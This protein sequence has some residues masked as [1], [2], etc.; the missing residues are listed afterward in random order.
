MS[1]GSA[2][3]LTIEQ[4]ATDY[5]VSTRTIRRRIA[6]GSISAKRLGTRLIRI[7]AESLDGLFVKVGA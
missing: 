2:R 6:D 3:W 4:V 5:H 7:D 1:K